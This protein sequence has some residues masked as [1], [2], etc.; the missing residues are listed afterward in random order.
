MKCGL[1]QVFLKCCTFGEV[2]QICSPA[3]VPKPKKNC[4]PPSTV[5]KESDNA[6]DNTGVIPSNG[7]NANVT[8]HNLPKKVDYVL[9]K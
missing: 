1:E 6:P 7:D 9:Q 4:V 8:T 5:T 3:T 2:K